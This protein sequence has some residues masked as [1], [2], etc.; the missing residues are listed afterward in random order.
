[1]ILENLIAGQKKAAGHQTI[2]GVN[3]ISK[4]KLSEHFHVAVPSEIEEAAEAAHNAWKSFRFSSGEKRATF[5][6]AIAEEIEACGDKL[7]ERA[8]QE[9]GLP[10][11]RIRGE[12]GRTCGQLRLFAELVREGSWVQ[13]RIDEAIPDRKPLPR[14]DIRKALEAIGPVAVF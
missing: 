5:L 10:G 9:S 7:V 8:M 6:E 11:G 1:M 13:A 4:E 12:R 2:Q 3:P 14:A